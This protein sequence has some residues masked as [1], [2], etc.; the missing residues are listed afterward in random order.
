MKDKITLLYP[1]GAGGN[2]LAGLLVNDY[3]CI[4]NNEYKSYQAPNTR[5]IDY[6]TWDNYDIIRT[7]YKEDA[8]IANRKTIIITETDQD[9]KRYINILAIIK[10]LLNPS[11]AFNQRL[12]MKNRL[13]TF[14]KLMRPLNV[15]D[16][17]CINSYTINKLKSSKFSIKSKA[18]FLLTLNNISLH[19]YIS[20][21][22]ID[23]Y[24]SDMWYNNFNNSIV[25]TYQDIIIKKIN[26]G[27]FSDFKS[28]L[29]NYHQGNINMLYTIDKKYNT[30][31]KEYIKNY[32]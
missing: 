28:Q 31:L 2:F 16:S 5:D 1:P 8:L 15:N 32:E 27:I 9:V 19:D 29:T 6:D 3:N 21:Y 22:D 7:H 4:G 10:H 13:T 24:N 26:L 20:E 30:N 17:F 23:G 14:N 11:S 25:Y 12:T 18:N